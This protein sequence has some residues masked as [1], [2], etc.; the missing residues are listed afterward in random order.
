MTHKELELLDF[1]KDLVLIF[2]SRR[3]LTW[4]NN[5]ATDVF[6]KHVTGEDFVKIIRDPRAITTLNKVIEKEGNNLS[7]YLTIAAPVEQQF[8]F[9]VNELSPE[10]REFGQVIILLRD[11][12]AITEANEFRSEFIAN[13]SHELRSPLSSL[14]GFI[15]TLLGPAK[16]DDGVRVKF[17]KLMENEAR[18]MSNLI[19]DLL[20]L[21]KLEAEEHIPPSDSVDINALAT[22]VITVARQRAAVHGMEIH[23]TA[24]SDIP[25]II[26]DID[27]LRRVIRNLVDNAIAYGRENSII[28]VSI[29]SVASVYPSNRPGVS[30]SVYNEGEGIKGEDIPRLTERFFRTDKARSRETG[31]TGLGLAIVKHAINRHRGDFVI[32]STLGKDATFTFSIPF[33]NNQK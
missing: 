8:E 13:L 24:G 27:E 6:G 5:S 17:L 32:Q 10:L 11:V 25:E 19:D 29:N 14:S 4:M 18:R 31:G 3:C 12:T 28:R 26:G 20:S 23:L 30:L 22:S 33:S 2:D 16:D 9:Q 21:S 15:E 1:V 7:G